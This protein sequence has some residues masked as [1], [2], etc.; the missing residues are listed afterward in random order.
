MKHGVGLHP[1]WPNL[2]FIPTS[3]ILHPLRMH[4]VYKKTAFASFSPT[5]PISL[6]FYASTWHLC[7]SIQGDFIR[8]NRYLSRQQEGLFKRRIRSCLP[9][10]I[11]RFITNPKA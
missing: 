2:A 1:A 10:T 7:L 6:S 11:E 5:C 3:P 4:S 8:G 9:Q